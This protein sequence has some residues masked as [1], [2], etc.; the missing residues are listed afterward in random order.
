MIG[1]QLISFTDI[2]SPIALPS[3]SQLSDDFVGAT[4]VASGFGWTTEGTCVLRYISSTTKILQPRLALTT[5]VTL[6]E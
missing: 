3:G 2:I 5:Y 6:C 1:I 4:A